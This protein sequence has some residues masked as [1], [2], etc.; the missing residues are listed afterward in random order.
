M[1]AGGITEISSQLKWPLRMATVLVV[2][3]LTDAL[4]VGFAPRPLL[5]A[6]LIPALTPLLT[7]IF[8]ILPML[9]NPRL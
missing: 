8:V 4:A 5:W 3:G 2:V 1:V 9:R 7:V 6:V